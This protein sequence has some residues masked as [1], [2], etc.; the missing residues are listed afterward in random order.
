MNRILILAI[1]VFSATVSAS[2]VVFESHRIQINLD[3]PNHAAAISDSGS[4][5]TSAGWNWFFVNKS[6]QIQLFKFN[7]AACTFKAVSARDTANLPLQIKSQSTSLAEFPDAQLICFESTT[8]GTSTFEISYAAVFNEEVANVRFSREAVGREVSGTILDQG[9]YLSPSSYFYPQGK[10]GMGTF[11]LIANVPSDWESISDGDA[12]STTVTGDRKAQVWQNPYKSDGCFF[13]AAPYVTLSTTVE[14]TKVTC[15][16]F[17]ADTSLAPNYLKATADYVEMYSELIGPYP[18]KNVTVAENF[19]PTGYGMPGWTLLGQSVLR[20]PFIISS[21]LG[22]EVLHNWWG[23][24]VYVDYSRGNWCE[25]LTVYGAD[26]RY[27][28]KESP[29]AAE[30]YRKDILKQY[31]SY[32]SKDKDFPL[33]D[34]TSRTSPNTRAIG[35]NKAMMVFHMIEEEIGSEAFFDAWKLVY[36]TYLGKQVG[37][38]EWLQAF[39]T[40]SHQD[41]ST[42]IPEWVNRAGAPELAVDISRTANGPQKGIKMVTLSLA[43]K[44]PDIYH[45]TVP[46]T[47]QEAAAKRDTNVVLDKSKVDVELIAPEGAMIAV[48]PNYHLFR[49]LY[50]EEVEPIISAV[51]GA[52]QQVFVLGAANAALDS[53]FRQFAAGVAED[54]AK[55]VAENSMSSVP[56]TSG[57]IWLNPTSLP[58]FVA[59]QTMITRD[60]IAIGSAR[61]LREG[62]SFILSGQNADGSQKYWVILSDDAASL[63]RLGQLVPHYGKYSYL[64]FNGAKN[65]AKGQWEVSQTPLN[66]VVR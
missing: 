22:H 15:L 27:K 34:F 37:W 65:I 26:Y 11:S 19:F 35:Y 63:P 48:D 51:L 53:A 21:S 9:A 18:F 1:S 4:L 47:I 17:E 42:V 55:V 49:R 16:F 5:T 32:V 66:V 62:H 13:M 57:L 28:L 8:S 45:L 20:L 23:N 31:V 29:A 54:S 61:F 64:A 39:E 6:A 33:R 7:G 58:E 24:S 46:I 12:M 56:P 40:T 14:S 44:G 10:D 43:Q 38:E 50:P 30:E 25:G 59:K 3:V 52:P 41:L 36:R 60:S 2:P